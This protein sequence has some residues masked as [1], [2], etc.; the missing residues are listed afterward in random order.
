MSDVLPVRRALVA[1][2]DKAGVAEFAAGTLPSRKLSRTTTLDLPAVGA[3][4]SIETNALIPRGGLT[5]TIEAP[6]IVTSTTRLAKMP[7]VPV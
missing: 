2:A 6:S 1:V 7:L 3:S 5:A 4:L